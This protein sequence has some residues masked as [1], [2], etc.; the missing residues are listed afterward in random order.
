VRRGLPIVAFVGYT[1]A[2]KSTLLNTLTRSDVLAEDRLF[3]TLDPTT[4]RLR[5]PREREIIIADT[6]GFIRDLPL[7]LAR[8]FRATLEELDEA[9][10][11]LHVVDAADPANDQQIA[12]VEAILADL[13]LAETRRILVMN[14]VDLLPDEE[15]AR[16]PRRIGDLPVVPISARDGATTA[17]LLEAIEG[18]LA[19]EGFTEAPPRSPADDASV[20]S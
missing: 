12:A 10:L 15:R 4:R 3:A 14:K 11:L 19:R 18:A 2:G 1:N 20:P 16:L 5:L 7:D 8:A 6:V 13:G 9:D 17:P